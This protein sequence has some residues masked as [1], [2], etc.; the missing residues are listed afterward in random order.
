[1]TVA[2]ENDRYITIAEKALEGMAKAANKGEFH[3]D[4][5][6]IHT[7]RSSS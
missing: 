5:I 1:V 3:V 7:I 2:P 4:I 6:P